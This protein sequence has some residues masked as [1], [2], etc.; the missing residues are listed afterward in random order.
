MLQIML[1]FYN[2]NLK[3]YA[4]IS[5]SIKLSCY[6]GIWRIFD[7]YNSFFY[8]SPLEEILSSDIPKNNLKKQTEKMNPKQTNRWK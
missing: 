2:K 6:I 7:T 4:Q 8:V 5:D 3:K 1:Q